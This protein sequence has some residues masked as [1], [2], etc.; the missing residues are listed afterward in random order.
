MLIKI[1]TGLADVVHTFNPSNQ[2]AERQVDFFPGIHGE[3]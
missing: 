2:K 3:F 1:K